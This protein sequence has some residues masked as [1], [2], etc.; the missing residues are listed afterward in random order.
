MDNK[1]KGFTLIELLAVI[2]ILALIMV[3]AVP[4]VLET[5]RSAQKESLYLYAQ[6][7]QSKAIARYTQDLDMNKENTDC[8]VYDISKNLDLSGTGDYEGWVKVSR[9]PT[10][11]GKRT[12][13][14]ELSHSDT[15]RYV[16]YCVAKGS[17]CTPN[18][19]FN[20]GEDNKKA[21]IERSLEAGEVLCA[22]YQY[23]DSNKVLKTADTQCVTYDKG[24]TLNDT[25]T[26]NVNV[27]LKDDTYAVENVLFKEDMSRDEFFAAI[28]DYNQ[29]HKN[30][31][32]KLA[33]ASPSC[34]AEESVKGT[35]TRGTTEVTNNEATT[36]GTTEA[37]SKTTS[38]RS[39]NVIDPS[40]N[41]TR[42]TSEVITSSSTTRATTTETT[43]TINVEDRSLLLT[44]L[45]IAGYNINFDPLKFYYTLDVPYNVTNLNI[46][47]TAE[48]PDV[49]V[50]QVAGNDYLGVGDNPVIV[51][52]FNQTTGAKANYR[53]NVT[54]FNETGVRPTSPTNPIVDPN[55]NEEGKPDPTIEESN[56]AL[57]Y[58]AIS[59]YDLDFDPDVYEYTLT[60]K[61][62]SKLYVNY[63]AAS[64]NAVVALYGNEEVKDGGEITLFVQSENGYYNKTYKIK[65]QFEQVASTGTKVLRGVA[66]GLGVLLIILLIIISLNKK[67]RSNNNSDT[68]EDKENNSEPDNN[69]TNANS[70]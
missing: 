65:I 67:K 47:A 16:K 36:R 12:A 3:I 19:A 39:T 9:T 68:V 5:M 61:G 10:N 45:N 57:A 24:T 28:E 43:T 54:R 7:L 38:T 17:S 42:G 6:S 34:T 66:V 44:S 33:I 2:I 64:E 20:A 13:R 50:V 59:G 31:A 21:V 41:T 56:A 26:Y 32:N 27:T 53:I 18:T 70:V 46:S 58:L 48:R 8:A 29:K 69:S 51:T 15:L 52:V 25:Y 63:R 62:E 4:A 22:N 37:S 49:S 40:S 35:T 60:T 23:A 1:K 14:I 30:D 11:S 55:N